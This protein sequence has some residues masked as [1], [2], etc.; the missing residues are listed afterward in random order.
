MIARILSI[1][2]PFWVYM[3]IVVLA[4]GLWRE[5]R[6]LEWLALVPAIAGV[7]A[8]FIFLPPVHRLFFDEDMYI[9]LAS[10]LAHAPVAQLTLLG[11]PDD[12]QVSTYYKEP[13]GWPVMLSF[14]FLV[15]GL[16]ETAAFIL[17]RV[18][19]GVAAAAVYQL[20]R[21]VV[22]TRL[23]AL[24]AAIFFAATP[25]CFWFSVSAGTDVPAALMM[26]LGMWGLLSANGALAAGGFAMAAQTRMELMALMPLVWMFGKLPLKWKIASA[27][28]VA[29]EVAH[30]G[31]V[32]SVSPI[33][34]QAEN[35]PSGFALGYA[36]GN[37]LD[38]IKYLFNPIAFPAGMT[39][40]GL[41]AVY[42][43]WRT[44]RAHPWLISVYPFGVLFCVYL[45]FYAGSFNVNPRYSI[46]ILAPLA[47]LA[48]SV[49]KRPVYI[50]ALMLSLALPY[51]Q[52]WE[53]TGY[54]EALAADH[55]IS[56]QFV[57]RVGPNDLVLSATP[58]MFMNQGLRAMDAVFASSRKDKI[59]EELRVRDKIW[60]HSGV[61][62]NRLD[63]VEASADRWMKSNFELHLIDSHEISGI[64]IA[65]YDV[66]PKLI[67]REAR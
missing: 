19:F 65:F 62:T 38:N 36:P 27:A 17:A 15:T 40:L 52:R 34:A 55:R 51:V 63:S 66:L 43:G 28:L 64:R 39:L 5:R 20:A 30:V 42:Q 31:W 29:A 6:K 41:I 35:V 12:V 58:Q 23:Q 9:N 2:A 50:A 26:L 11:S 7:L 8:S 61:R 44:S 60:Y 4:L 53:F 48:V 46:Q 54:L 21:G 3:T 24:A 25:A 22:E 57:P 14:V 49:L 1:A 56:V 45:L 37:L 33:L 67:D 47:I 10:N 18:L 16:S 13:S 32:M 59:D